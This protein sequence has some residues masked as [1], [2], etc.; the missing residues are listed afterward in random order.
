MVVLER[1]VCDLSFCMSDLET[2]LLMQISHLEAVYMMTGPSLLSCMHAA[3][4]PGEPQAIIVL[5]QL[6]WL[7]VQR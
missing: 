1:I 7:Q 5:S 6:A 4:S 2:G 3:L